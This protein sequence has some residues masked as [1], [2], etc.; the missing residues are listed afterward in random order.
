[1]EKKK[2][3]KL[4]SATY[5]H[6]HSP[7]LEPSP[8]GAVSVDDV[9]EMAGLIGLSFNGSMIELRNRIEAI[10]LGQGH[11]WAGLQQ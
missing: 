1:M 4:L 11:D 10:L 2:K 3:L 7:P 5:N 6:V 9:I 8:F